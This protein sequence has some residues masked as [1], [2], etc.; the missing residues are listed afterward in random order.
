M[1][2]KIMDFNKLAEE[3]K[4]QD[5]FRNDVL[6]F[7]N[8][9]VEEIRSYFIPAKK[10]FQMDLSGISSEKLKQ[11]F[12][13]YL[14]LI[15]T[16]STPFPYTSDIFLRLFDFSK[17]LESVTYDSFF[18]I[19]DTEGEN[20]K[21]CDFFKK[22]G[23]KYL[24]DV[25]RILDR[26]IFVLSEFYDSRTGFD[27]DYWLISSFKISPER[28]NLPANINSLNFYRIKNEENRE[29]VKTWFK[30][31]IGGTELSFSTI[32]NYLSYLLNYCNYFGDCSL[33][34]ISRKQFEKFKE[35]IKD[36]SSNYKNK[37]YHAISDMYCY[38]AIKGIFTKQSPVLSSDFI[39]ESGNKHFE[40]SVSDFTILQIFRHLHKLPFH[41]MLMYLINYSTG[42]RVVDICQLKTDCL[43]KSEKCYFIR[44]YQQKM[45]KD[46][47]VPVS[48][49]L[50]ELIEKRVA[51]ISALDYEEKYLFFRKQ[52]LPITTSRYRETMKRFCNEHHIT[53]E[54]G[55]PY[56]FKAHSY[57]H[58]IATDLEENYGVSLEV[59]QLV[60][61]GHS[62]I[63]M[64]LRYI[65]STDE[66]RKMKNDEY[67][68]Y[69]GASVSLSNNLEKPAW[70]K[71]NFSKH[72]LPNGICGNPAALGV[73]PHSMA[74]L[75]CKYFRTSKRF[76]E[77]HKK[78]LEELEKN[79]LLYEK[80][81]WLP[82]LETSRK[83]KRILE[84]IIESIERS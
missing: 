4:I 53:N 42:M 50:G 32:M 61:L 21:I 60:V 9:P 77:A 44:Y 11:E 73:C 5:F 3:R 26:L 37:T 10:Y 76:L 22:A 80:N 58:T 41:I 36:K 46:H 7:K 18:E 15:F 81:N 17:Y 69:Q 8:F 62:N 31:L 59:I 43:I 20:E 55:T 68:D 67:F 45:Q 39:R 64:T 49:A 79:I 57:R 65:D 78:Q 83:Q 72:I 6:N 12:R 71:E 63:Q 38:L 23:F 34:D 82:N 54:D 24:T 14:Y 51:D 30:Y 27:R 66:Y 75:D 33:L 84:R 28:L 74:C 29:L 13:D 35:T 52:N 25:K 47:A 70:V 56:Q 48:S 2:E 1:E 19:E 16:N 40:N